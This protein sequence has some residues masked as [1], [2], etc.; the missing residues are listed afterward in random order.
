[1]ASPD[2]YE[3]LA[4]NLSDIS[5]A[6]AE[7]EA[8]V[9]QTRQLSEQM[10][11]AKT[12]KDQFIPGTGKTAAGMA[13]ESL[14]NLEAQNLKQKVAAAA[15][16]ENLSIVLGQDLA[17]LAHQQ[18]QLTAKIQ[19]DSSVSL[20]DDPLTAIANA[21]T[22]PWDEQA[23]AGLTQKIDVTNKAMN[24]V[25]QHVQNSAQT[26][27][28]IKTRVTEASI[29][30]ESAAI[31]NFFSE[32]AASA[33]LEAIK[34]NADAVNHVLTLDSKASEVMLRRSQLRDQE[35]ARAQR[36]EQHKAAMAQYDRAAAKAK[37]EEDVDAYVFSRVNAALLKE[38]KN[39]I[40]A[41]RY[42]VLK[43]TSAQF[44][45]QMFKKGIELEIQGPA[46]YTHGDNIEERFAWQNAVGWQPDSQKPAQLTVMEWQGVSLSNGKELGGTDKNRASILANQ[47]FNKRWNDEQ[48]N[49]V[50]GSPFRAPSPVV[51][52]RNSNIIKNPIWQKYV[53]P[54]L[55]EGNAYSPLSE[56]TVLNA[57]A[58][59][60]VNGDVK[61]TEAAAFVAHV[62]QEAANINNTLNE[63]KKIT[64]REQTKYG[65][66]ARSGYLFGKESVDLADQ[67]GAQV[68]LQGAV[69]AKFG[70]PGL[71]TMQNGKQ[72]YS[73]PTGQPDVVYEA[74]R[75]ANEELG[76]K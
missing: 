31:A 61:S 76:I 49:I 16:F 17:S 18:R 68:A 4:T 55:N 23:L 67:V 60:V 71:G 42:K 54:T 7:A 9:I 37:S 35:E 28:A 73:I 64:G 43:G 69:V 22:L 26:A 72:T 70:L 19:Q 39:P 32:R 6:K 63:F 50:E 47:Q 59:A 46:G 65:Y 8:A 30:S 12:A 40:D 53:Q 3:A 52:A 5:K 75:K 2:L 14:G 66:R 20:F 34:T 10:V 21:F 13:V 41:T 15:D 58:A 25:N 27:E 24:S 44:I 29:A 1:M 33:K 38:G 74:Y 11:A 51:Y 45:D 62:F 56:G 57:A 48:G 36:A